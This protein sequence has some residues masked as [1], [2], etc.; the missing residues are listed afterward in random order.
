MLCEW[1]T[2]ALQPRMHGPGFRP[3]TSTKRRAGRPPRL[4]CLCAGLGPQKSALCPVQYTGHYA[5]GVWTVRQAGE[6]FV[7]PCGSEAR[8]KKPSRHLVCG[9]A[10]PLQV[11][12]LLQE[13]FVPSNAALAKKANA[14]SRD[15]TPA[16]RVRTKL[17]W[18][19]VLATMQRQHEGIIEIQCLEGGPGAESKPEFARVRSSRCRVSRFCFVSPWIGAP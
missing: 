19:T 16:F 3:A 13:H 8:T 14:W 4:L 10:W 2:R 9:A 5:D 1:G 11:S 12:T 18:R 6:H 7:A 17:G 15:Q